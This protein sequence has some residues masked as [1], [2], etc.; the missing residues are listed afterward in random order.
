MGVRHERGQ[1]MRGRIRQGAALG[2]RTGLLLTG[3]AVI[4]LLVTRAGSWSDIL[5]AIVLV[6]V[7]YLLGGLA[8]GGII[9]MLQPLSRGPVGFLLTATVA[10]APLFA[11]LLFIVYGFSWTLET[12][13]VLLITT[14]LF[15]AAT[16][17]AWFVLGG[18]HTS[19]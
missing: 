17:L 3:L 2:A 6:A 10:G 18:R 1:S 19:E 11:A 16:T 13:I 12:T 8:V 4:G 7:L 14:P 9:G 15:A 5:G